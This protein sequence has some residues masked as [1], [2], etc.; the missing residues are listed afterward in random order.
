[1]DERG[2]AHFDGG[3]FNNDLTPYSEP[4]PSPYHSTLI[5]PF[6][7]RIR[8]LTAGVGEIVWEVTGTAPPPLENG[9]LFVARYAGE[10]IVD[11][12]RAQVTI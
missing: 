7:D 6:W 8:P 1:M 5:A 3:G 11:V 2:A 4:L 12:T 9:A 10:R